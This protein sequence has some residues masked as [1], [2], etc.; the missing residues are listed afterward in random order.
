MLGENEFGVKSTSTLESL[1]ETLEVAALAPG[2]LKYGKTVDINHL[3]LSLAYAHSNILTEKA[4]EQGVRLTRELESCSV[5]V[6]AK[7]LRALTLLHTTGRATRPLD[8][9]RI[10]TAG[11]HPA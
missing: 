8:L 1:Y 6:R 7:G 4:K 9:V 11:P 3:H 5:C 2:V 10:D